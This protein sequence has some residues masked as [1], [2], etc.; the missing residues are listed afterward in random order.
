MHE[1]IYMQAPFH[2]HRWNYTLQIT[3][4]GFIPPGVVGSVNQT[5]L[6]VLEMQEH[7]E[8]R[9][10]CLGLSWLIIPWLD[11][12][13]PRNVRIFLVSFEI[14]KSNKD[15]LNGI[16]MKDFYIHLS[17]ACMLKVSLALLW[18]LLVCEMLQ[19]GVGEG[20][21]NEK[22]PHFIYFFKVW[23]TDQLKTVSYCMLWANEQ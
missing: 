6:E 12:P 9:Q 10:V 18:W 16:K 22:G 15:N 1:N 13:G 11:T 21:I 17:S 19:A 14:K 5:G 20:K 2:D 3:S 8:V 4:D 7:G 23:Q